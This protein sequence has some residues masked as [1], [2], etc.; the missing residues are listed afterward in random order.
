MEYFSIFYVIKFFFILK[1]QTMAISIYQDKIESR[2]WLVFRTNE[3]VGKQDV[4]FVS[5]SGI[6][7][8]DFKGNSANWLREELEIHAPIPVNNIPVTVP[9][10][11][12]EPGYYFVPSFKSRNWVVFTSLN[13]IFNESHAVN[14]GHAV[15]TFQL[16]NPQSLT[17]NAVIKSIVAVRDTDAHL[18]RVGYKAELLVYFDKY[19]KRATV[20]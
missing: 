16:T 14:S 20:K 4:F 19:I 10:P 12:P 18:F 6:A 5:L 15:D 7:V 13:S 1:L 11:A 17:D 8:F 3:K 9:P 2:H